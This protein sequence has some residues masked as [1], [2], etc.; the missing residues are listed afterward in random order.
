MSVAA[1]TQKNSCDK[2]IWH[3]T[4]RCVLSLIYFYSTEPHPD[5]KG[6]LSSVSPNACR[7]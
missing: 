5:D 1:P 6:K 2:S 4:L 3:L 7:Q